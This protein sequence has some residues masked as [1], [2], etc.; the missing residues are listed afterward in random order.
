MVAAVR[1]VERALGSPRKRPS[2]S[3]MRNRSIVRKSIVAAAGIQKGE[4]FSPS[5]L[6]VKRP[7]RGLPPSRYWGLLGRKAPRRFRK[8]EEI[9]A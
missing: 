3:E 2:A 8:D 4:A 5:N 6:A 9:K 1:Q 7:G